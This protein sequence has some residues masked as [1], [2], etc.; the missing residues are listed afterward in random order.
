MPLEETR[1][2]K[3]YKE[4]DSLLYENIPGKII[5]KKSIKLNG[6]NGLDI[7]NKTR[8]GDIQR[9]QIYI[10]PFEVLIFKMSGKEYY[11]DGPEAG[12]FFGSIE[13]PENENRLVNFEPQ[14]GG[15]KINLPQQPHQFLN[16]TT[17][18]DIDRWEYEATDKDAG[19]SFLI[20]K[21]T[22]NNFNFLD[23]DTFDL[24]L[25]NES[26]KKSKFIQEQVNSKHGLF[27][28]HPCMDVTL[29]LNDSSFIRRENYY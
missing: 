2:K 18:D 12:K 23:Q 5:E 28:G 25:I 7:T 1:S 10:T 9:Y 8:R 21:K 11:V 16:T 15:F 19:N 20:L 14:S 29:K 22:I 3:I 24:D 26:F 27:K 6:Y 13:L 17:A 4:I